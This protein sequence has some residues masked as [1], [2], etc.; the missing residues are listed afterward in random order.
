[1]V[2]ESRQDQ[3]LTIGEILPIRES[4]SDAVFI[5]SS[6]GRCLWCNSTCEELY[7]IDMED[8]QGRLVEY[9]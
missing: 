6:E 7:D 8:I 5:D 4:I 2:I 1:M 3:S 9:L